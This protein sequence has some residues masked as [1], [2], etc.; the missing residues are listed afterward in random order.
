M[1]P[2]VGKRVLD[3]DDGVLAQIQ[4]GAPNLKVQRVEAC[5]GT[6]RLRLPG[7]D[8]DPE[9]I[10][11]EIDRGQRPHHGSVNGTWPS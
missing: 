3:D 7:A 1:V 9:T 10:P 6:E 5:R 11:V 2:R 4:K 8:A